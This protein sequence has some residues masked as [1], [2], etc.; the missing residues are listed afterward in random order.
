MKSFVATVFL[1]S[2]GLVSL[3]QTSLYNTTE[4]IEIDYT[5]ALGVHYI[6]TIE[7]GHTLY[8]LSRIFQ[9]TPKR[10]MAF[11]NQSPTAPLLLGQR[12]R[13]PF[14]DKILYTGPSVKQFA[15][16]NFL[17]VYYTIKPQETVYRISRVYFDQDAEIIL[18]R[19]N[20]NGTDLQIGQRLLMGWIPIDPAT[21]TG[22]STEVVA[23]PPRPEPST[24]E[25]P[26]KEV[27]P[28]KVKVVTDDNPIRPDTPFVD[29]ALPER[30]RPA[31]PVEDLVEYQANGLAF[32]NKASEDKDNLFALHPT[33]RI[34]S[35]I[36]IYN[37]QL[38][39]RTFAKV[40]A[41]IPPGTYPD[42]IDVI[43]SPR[44]AYTL[45]ALNSEFRVRMK[46]F[47]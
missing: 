11:N 20:L 37:P 29:L 19:N 32:W 13:L 18:Q 30:D 7:K 33:A 14:D 46:F 22:P 25:Q 12:I 47:E 16:G 15:N 36:E 24:D 1:L 40:I 8:A 10:I 34:N 6:H 45:G 5:D 4:G 41:R 2:T 17:P 39:R 21:G 43:V 42:N 38:Q 27:L 9:V 3:A 23:E 35:L 31:T 44:V 26:Q 28:Q